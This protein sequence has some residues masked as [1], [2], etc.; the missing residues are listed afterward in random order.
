MSVYINTKGLNTDL[1]WYV[2]FSGSLVDFGNILGNSSHKFNLASC[3]DR[4][5]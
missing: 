1:D 2:C 3:H 5:T 4:V